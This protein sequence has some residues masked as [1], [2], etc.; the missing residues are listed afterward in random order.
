MRRRVL[1][2][3]YV[4]R[5]QAATSPFTAPFQEHITLWVWGS[6][7]T[8]TGLSQR[9]RSLLTIGLLTALHCTDELTVHVRAAVR[10][11]LTA[12]EIGEVLLHTSAYA[13][14]P[15]ANAA[16]STVQAA[17]AEMGIDGA[18]PRDDG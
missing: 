10:G 5:A 18:Q 3:D 16:F 15:A 8:R 4:D 11:G 14:V 13:G 12:E 7:W 6:V 17:L 2:D 1:G 9:D